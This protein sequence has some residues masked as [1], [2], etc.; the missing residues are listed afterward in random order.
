VKKFNKPENQILDMKQFFFCNKENITD[1]LGKNQSP[2]P[3]MCR[4]FSE[5]DIGNR[6]TGRRFPDSGKEFS[7][8]LNYPIAKRNT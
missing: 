1:W 8:E 6:P 5:A 4:S 7:S 3:L 2:L